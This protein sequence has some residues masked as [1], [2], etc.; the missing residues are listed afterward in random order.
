VAL[1]ATALTLALSLGLASLV[2]ALQARGSRVAARIADV[3]GLLPIAASP[4]VIGIAFIIVLRPLADPFALAL[5][6]TAIV[7]AAMAT[8]F[9]LRI[10]TPAIRLA[11]EE[12]GRLADSLGLTGWT[13]IRVLYLPRLK[14]PLG[15][16]AGLSGALAMGDLG[17]IALFSTPDAPTL[18]LLMHLLANSR[19]VDAAYGAALVLLALSFGV[20]W[21]FDRL[22]RR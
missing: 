2:V 16:A 13:R 18:P 11:L 10:L 19:Q 5:P 6:L 4:F 17:V 20:F 22:G 12:H 14:Q 21:M 7:N 15:F 1:V 9:A 8:P 3:A